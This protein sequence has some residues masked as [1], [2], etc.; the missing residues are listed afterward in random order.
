[1]PIQ[2]PEHSL[3]SFLPPSGGILTGT[4]SLTVKPLAVNLHLRSQ[5]APRYTTDY[6][7]LNQSRDII[8]ETSH[9]IASGE[10]LESYTE[11]S[12]SP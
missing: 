7:S 3:P 8:A 1:M 10:L 9:A 11:V 4:D 6:G 5:A 2:L 12:V